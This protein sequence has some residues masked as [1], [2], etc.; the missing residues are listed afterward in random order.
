M[1]PS[2]HPPAPPSPGIPSLSSLLPSPAPLTPQTH[3]SLPIPPA[4]LLPLSNL[5]NDDTSAASYHGYPATAAPGSRSLAKSKPAIAKG[6]H[7]TVAGSALTNYACPGFWVIGGFLSFPGPITA[8][9]RV[10]GA[11]LTARRWITISMATLVLGIINTVGNFVKG[12][13]KELNDAVP[14]RAESDPG[15]DDFGKSS[16][17]RPSASLTFKTT[18]VLVT[19]R[20]A[21]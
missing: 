7:P 6:S 16:G 4:S 14:H 5:P 2:P 8:W 12:P 20:E 15:A 21:Q 3:T 19:L 13:L 9:N 10:P 1:S 11:D 18:Q 17:L